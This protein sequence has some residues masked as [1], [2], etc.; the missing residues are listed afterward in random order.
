MD[1]KKPSKISRPVPQNDVRHIPLHRMDTGR[2]KRFLR[3]FYALLAIVVASALAIYLYTALAVAQKIDTTKY[4]VVY[5][6]NGQA[7]FGK[8]QNTAGD[9]LV[10]TTPYV[11]QA[12]TITNEAEKKDASSQTTLVKA[13]AQ[14]YG[15]E[16]SIAIKSSQVLF[17]QNLR[18]DSKITQ[19]IKAKQ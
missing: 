18:D 15:P 7:Y 19:A 13:S 6:S 1:I 14:V 2:A 4:Q 16:E 8:L 10:M 9:Y 11:A 5:L 12:V 17:W 3:V